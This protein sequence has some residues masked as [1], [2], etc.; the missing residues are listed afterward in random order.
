MYQTAYSMDNPM[1]QIVYYLTYLGI[2]IALILSL[3]RILHRAG[4]VLLDDAFPASRTLVR[5]VS[6]LLDIGFYLMSFGYVATL[7]PTYETLHD[8]GEVVKME[9]GKLGGLLLLLGCV[10]LFNMLLLAFFRRRGGPAS[11]LTV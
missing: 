6:Q 3:G 8:A 9:S 10:H 4:R 1:Y 5:A 7:T 2:C 11:S